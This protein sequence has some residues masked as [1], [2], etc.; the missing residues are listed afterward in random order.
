[1]TLVRPLLGGLEA[2]ISLEYPVESVVVGELAVAAATPT[3]S[4]A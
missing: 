1:V 4:A 2:W 3:G